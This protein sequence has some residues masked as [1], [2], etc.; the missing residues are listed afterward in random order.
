MPLVPTCASM[1]EVFRKAKEASRGE[2][3]Y[4]HMLFD[5]PA[6]ALTLYRMLVP[7]LNFDLSTEF[8]NSVPENGFELWQLLN[9][10]L[11]PPRADFE[12][13]LTNDI[14][15]HARTS[16]TSFEQ[17]VK[18]IS[19]P[20]AASSGLTPATTWTWSCLVRSS[21]PPWLKIP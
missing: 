15:K 13:H 16:C 5:Y 2:D 20:S 4:D 3:P 21:A 1:S 17:T 10:K 6:T 7:K 14:R 11:A 12:F 19:R 8:H 18:S 9:H